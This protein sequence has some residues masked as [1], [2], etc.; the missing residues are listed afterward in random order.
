MTMQQQL[1]TN[2]SGLLPTV[3]EPLVF[4]PGDGAS[5]R[6]ASSLIRANPPTRFFAIARD[7]EALLGDIFT[8]EPEV[9][10]VSYIERLARGHDLELLWAGW[11]VFLYLCGRP[12]QEAPPYLPRW[13]GDWH[14][15]LAVLPIATYQVSGSYGNAT[16]TIQRAG[17]TAFSALIADTIGRRRGEV[18]GCTSTLVALESAEEWIKEE[19]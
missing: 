17:P 8:L 16:I 18:L 13:H 6:I 10:F 5:Y 11:R 2:I 1:P 12:D 3:L 4:R 15:A 9:P 7:D 19:R 14:T